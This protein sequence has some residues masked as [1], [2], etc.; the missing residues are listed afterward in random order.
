M[1][2]EKH[3]ECVGVGVGPANLSLAS[4]LHGCP[5]LPNLFL[6][7]GEVFRWHDGQQIPDATLQ[8][9][10]FKDLVSLSDPTNPFSF[11]S[12]LKEKGRIYHFI[13]A[14]FSAVPRQEFRNYLEWASRRNQNVVFGE[15]VVSVEFDGV[16]VVRTNRRTVTASNVSVGI[17]R[18][19][20]VPAVARDHLGPTQFHVSE[21]MP[22]SRDLA[23]KRV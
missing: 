3:Y 8:V 23:G 15:E 10:I 20:W 5:G 11:L 7:K 16:F 22:L 19:A 18:H 6:E 17:G 1:S 2:D 4:L 13:N 14:Q 21:F 12:Y 9:S